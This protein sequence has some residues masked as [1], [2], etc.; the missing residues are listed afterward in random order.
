M[1]NNARAIT[2]AA[3]IAAVYALLT[4]IFQPLSFGAVQLRIAEALTLL[5]L[6]TPAATPGLFVGCLL[7]NLLGGA[8]WYDI[9]FGSVATLLAALAARKLRGRPW[10]AAAMPALFNG[11][12]IGPVVYF[13]YV[14]APGAAVSWSVLLSSVGSVSLGEIVV[15]YVPGMLLVKLLRRLPEEL[16][17][18]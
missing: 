11:L 2:H 5:P 12:I 14:R 1:K 18:L 15:C 4:V 7:A 16:M 10:I 9:L 3:L 6:I 13:A 8:V 17:K